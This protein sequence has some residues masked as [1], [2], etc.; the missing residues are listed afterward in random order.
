VAWSIEKTNWLFFVV[1]CVLV[2]VWGWRVIFFYS[3]LY[4][5]A[6]MGSQLVVDCGGLEVFGAVQPAYIKVNIF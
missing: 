1:W 2:L 5:K 6:E 3:P 4:L